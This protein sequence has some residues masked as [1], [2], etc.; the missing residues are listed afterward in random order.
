MPD[1][2]QF[3]NIALL[4]IAL[5]FL[6]LA[7]VYVVRGLVAR[8]GT[9]ASR[10]NVGRQ[11]ARTTMLGSWLRAAVLGVIGAVLLLI[12]VVGFLPGETSVVEPGVDAPALIDSPDDSSPTATAT[13]LVEGPVVLPPT[14]DASGS[15]PAAAPSATP[16]LIPSPT[17]ITDTTTPVP[18]VTPASEVGTPVVITPTV[19]VTLPPEPTPTATLPPNGARVSSVAGLNVRATPGGEVIELI[20]DGAIVTLLDGLQTINEFVWQQ[21]RTTAGNEG[22]VAADFLV[23]E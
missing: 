23:T 3:I 1:L 19:V 6:A 16:T 7:T 20:P 10:Y 14:S 4:V 13:P 8:S 11:Q 12:A 5:F 15:M 22:W 18:T 21:V 2:D 17:P 9:Q